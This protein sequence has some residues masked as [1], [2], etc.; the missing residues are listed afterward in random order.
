M[1]GESRLNIYVL[2]PD[3]SSRQ[4]ERI[5]A[6]ISTGLRSLPRWLFDLLQQRIEAL[7]VTSLP[8]II[9]PQPPA[10]PFRALSL[11]RV[12]SRP[13]VKLTPRLRPDGVDW[14]QDL[15]RL[16]AKAIA[17]VLSHQTTSIP[18]SGA[19]GTPRWRRT[20]FATRLRSP[21]ANHT[22]T[23]ILVC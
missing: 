20:A 7:G 6:Q 23:L 2:G 19:V 4:R 18:R 10:T 14:G 21:S 15:S 16:L 22:T 13:A 5:Q 12:E 17:W 8:L 3:L 9:E 11:G 1:L